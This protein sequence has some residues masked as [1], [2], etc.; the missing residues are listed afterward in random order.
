[1]D[2]F[3]KNP[4]GKTYTHV[5]PVTY[6]S[7]EQCAPNFF[8]GRFPVLSSDLG[9]KSSLDGTIIYKYS[10]AGI[11]AQFHGKTIKVNVYILDRAFHQSNSVESDDIIIK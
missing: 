4:D 7:F 1:M 5:D 9:K 6:F 10:S 3:I 8:N 2:V 11:Y